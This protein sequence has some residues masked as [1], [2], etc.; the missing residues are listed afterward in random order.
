MNKILIASLF[1]VT[2][3]F[4]IIILKYK[5]RIEDFPEKLSDKQKKYMHAMPVVTV[6]LSIAFVYRNEYIDP[7]FA[8]KYLLVIFLLWIVALI[9][10]EKKIIPN[11]LLIMALG[12]RLLILLLEIPIYKTQ[13]ISLVIWDICGCLIIFVLCIVLRIIAKNGLGMGDVKLFSI[14]P[15]LIGIMTGF[16]LMFYSMI[17]VFVEAVFLLATK[18]AKKSDSVAF[19]PAILVGALLLSLT[20]IF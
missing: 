20:F 10:Y 5:N 9:D 3:F 16:Q 6:F 19:G 15:L 14:I 8:T 1:L 11:K 2:I 13:I 12:I 4:N 18:K 17:A 7:I